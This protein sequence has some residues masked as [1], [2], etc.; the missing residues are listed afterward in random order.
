M[1]KRNEFQQYE[2]TKLVWFKYQLQQEKFLKQTQEGKAIQ[3]RRDEMWLFE[4]DTLLGPTRA[5]IIVSKG[6]DKLKYD[7][8]LG[9]NKEK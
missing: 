4:V 2:Y 9:G 5:E 8:I 1:T 3:L 6:V 7:L